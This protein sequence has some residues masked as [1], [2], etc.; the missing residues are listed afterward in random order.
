MSKLVK[1]IRKNYKNARNL[2][3]IGTGFGF[4]EEL[5]DNFASV[6]IISTLTDPI[7]RRNLIYKEDFTLIDNLPEID[8]IFM[9]RNQDIHV[10]HLKTLLIKYHPTIFVEGDEIFGRREYKFLQQYNF[11]V[12]ERYGAYH[13]WTFQK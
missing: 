11:A 3:V 2:L 9:D 7:K 13:I 5:C 6:F 12:V 10:E 8:M 1:R 4:L